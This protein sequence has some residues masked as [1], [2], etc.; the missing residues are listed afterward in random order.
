MVV[1]VLIMLTMIMM[2]MM[3][4]IMTLTVMVTTPCLLIATTASTSIT[5][6]IALTLFTENSIFVTLLDNLLFQLLQLSLR[7]RLLCAPSPLQAVATDD[8]DD[9]Q[10]DEQEDDGADDAAG[11][12]VEVSVGGAGGGGRLWVVAGGHV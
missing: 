1:V 5:K 8:E 6:Y 12:D 10:D 11:H 3:M 9:E 7:Q 2:M 4:I